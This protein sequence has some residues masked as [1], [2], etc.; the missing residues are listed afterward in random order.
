MFDLGKRFALHR[1]MK[2]TLIILSVLALGLLALAACKTNGMALTTRGQLLKIN[3][4]HPTDLPDQGEDNLRI[5]VANRG[6]N[7]MQNVLVDVELP[8]QVVVLDEVHDRGMESSH[9]PGT[10]L[11]HYSIGNLQPADTSKVT[12][13]VRTSFGNMSQTG[14]VKVTAWQKDLPSD[15]LVETALIK[16]RK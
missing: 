10:N 15:R 1:G 4:V 16:L 8:P 5:E 12:Y 6:V 3:I 9:D 2:R 11:Y 13:K 14:D 7:N